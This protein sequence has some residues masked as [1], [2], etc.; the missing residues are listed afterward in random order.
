M[1]SWAEPRARRHPASPLCL[2][3]VIASFFRAQEPPVEL[4]DRSLQVL[5]L[6]TQHLPPAL[7]PDPMLS[8]HFLAALRCVGDADSACG[9]GAEAEEGRARQGAGFS[10]RRLHDALCARLPE[11]ATLVLLYLLLHGSP[12]RMP[13][14][15]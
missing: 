5:L 7:F 4:A 6:L 11:E 1:R 15:L 3:Q 14:E 2:L 8:N 13:A 12:A 9:S 10:V